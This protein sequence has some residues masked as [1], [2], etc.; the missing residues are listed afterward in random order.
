M[1]FTTMSDTPDLT[2]N[3]LV[4]QVRAKL[5]RKRWGRSTFALLVGNNSRI[6][7]RFSR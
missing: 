6:Y 2:M 4:M 5:K 7:C 3:E 1:V